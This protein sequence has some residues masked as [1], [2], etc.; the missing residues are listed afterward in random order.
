MKKKQ[1]K[2]LTPDEQKIILDRISMHVVLTFST[3]IFGGLFGLGVSIEIYEGD[4]LMKDVLGK[5]IFGIVACL[6]V[7]LIITIKDK[8]KK[9]KKK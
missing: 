8:K 6:I 4:L 9:G 2:Q 5:V 1:K 3:I 7:L